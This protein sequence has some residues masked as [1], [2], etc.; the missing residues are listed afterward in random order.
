[1]FDKMLLHDIIVELQKIFA[2]IV[3]LINP[4]FCP[5][6][7]SFDMAPDN[8]LC[9]ECDKHITPIVT[10]TIEITPSYSMKVF[11]ISAY[12][13]PLKR[14][15]LAKRYR[16]IAVCKTLAQM[17]WRKTDLK[18]QEFD[19]IVPVPLHWTRY[20]WRGYNQ[21]EEIAQTLGALAQKPVETKLVTKIKRTKYQLSLS[22]LLRRENVEDAFSIEQLPNK[23]AYVGKHILIVD[24]LLT[25][26]AT[27]K[28]VGREL[29]KLRPA[30]ITAVVVCRV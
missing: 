8:E 29:I 15:V 16:N 11:A 12:Q 28:A 18:N 26:G 10:T 2:S 6:C 24:D 21:A 19:C 1:M 3:T 7:K 5:A 27:L 22:K 9:D 25:T 23:R 17:I 13:N 14:M 30:Q 4:P 20:A